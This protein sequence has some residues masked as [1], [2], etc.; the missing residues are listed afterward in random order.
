MTLLRCATG[1]AWSVIMFEC[2]KSYDILYQCNEE[3]SYELL[4]KDGIDPSKWDGPRGC[5]SRFNAVV[6][7][8]IF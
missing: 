5:G 3:E 8:L 2:S 4:I 6:F 7:H 1:E